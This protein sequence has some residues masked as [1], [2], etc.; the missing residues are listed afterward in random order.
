LELIMTYIVGGI[1]MDLPLILGAGV[2]KHPSKL[3]P[4]LRAD[5]PVGA[6][7]TGSFTPAARK[8]NTPAPQQWPD[9]WTDFEESQ[10]M[11]NSWGMPNVG[12][13]AASLALSDMSIH[14]AVAR[15]LPI[16]TRT[17]IIEQ[18]DWQVPDRYTFGED[19]HVIPLCAGETMQYRLAA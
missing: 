5:A 11:L 14:G 4:Y 7:V 12:F 1:A 19:D 10:F 3:A 15:K 16:N 13:E 18:H 8:P 6:V 17:V 9:N 2:A